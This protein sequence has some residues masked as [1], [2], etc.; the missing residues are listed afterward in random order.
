MKFAKTF[1]AAAALT[2]STAMLLSAC[3]SKKDDATNAPSNTQAPATATEA[4]AAT[5]PPQNA[6]A[7]TGTK[8]QAK[9]ENGYRIIRIATWY[10]HDEYSS[11][12][13]LDDKDQYQTS[14]EGYTAR[15]ENMK[16]VEERYKVKFEFERTTFEGIQVSLDEGV[17]SGMPEFDL[18]E[19]DIQF[20]MPAALNGQAYAL[21]DLTTPENGVFTTKQV[22]IGQKFPSQDQT[23]L[24]NIYSEGVGAYILGFNWTML[25]AKGLENP[26]D[27]Y[28]RGEWTWAKF[29]DYATQMTD[30]SANPPIYGFT[31]LWINHLDGFL[32]SNGAQIAATPQGGLTSTPTGEV[33]DL[34]KRLYVDLKVARPWNSDD[35]EVNNRYSD[36][37]A[38]FFTAN[39]WIFNSDS[40]N[41][42]GGQDYPLNYEFGVVPYPVG[43]SGNQSTNS[44]GSV[45]G[46]FYLIP[47]G[48]EDPA[49]VYQAAYDYWNWYND[50]YQNTKGYDVIDPDDVPISWNQQQFI[51]A[52][53]GNEGLG[54]NNA[55]LA[56]IA[57]H[58]LSF[59][60]YAS[61]SIKDSD[62]NNFDLPTVLKG[63]MTPA[64][65]VETFKQPLE[66]Q[67]RTIYK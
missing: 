65:F 18:Y 9:Y 63:E 31:G 33:L 49:T 57:G 28:D 55:R 52:A 13:A 54:E 8:G 25:Q 3:G 64:Q 34:F 43:P 19:A 29:E 42:G 6:N 51:S 56:D 17:L 16:A 5:N 20:G 53:H 38:A 30:L 40:E 22:F 60:P 23:Y 14:P 66:D 44:H 12:Q 58:S 35:W 45:V 62:G 39:D 61:L 59:D 1:K 46:N 37:T 50:D 11:S 10:D 48:V 27:L 67:L 15:Y 32:R 41:Y 47:K 21:E 7:P 4:P 26:Q 2:L 36:G 24:W